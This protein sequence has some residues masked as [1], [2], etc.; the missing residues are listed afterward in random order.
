MITYQSASFLVFILVFTLQD[1]I[2]FGRKKHSF[3][4]VHTRAYLKKWAGE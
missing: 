4:A 1:K 3:Y 2:T